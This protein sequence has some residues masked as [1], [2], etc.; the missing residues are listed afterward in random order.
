MSATATTS[1]I[2]PR[3]TPEILKVDPA[4][5]LEYMTWFVPSPK[6]QDKLTREVDLEKAALTQTASAIR[7]CLQSGDGPHINPTILSPAAK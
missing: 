7:Y 1:W 2:P 4:L 3:P 5:I 6:P